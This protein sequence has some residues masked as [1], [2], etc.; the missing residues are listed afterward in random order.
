MT[1]G[2]SDYE[3]NALDSRRMEDAME[4]RALTESRNRL[5]ESSLVASNTKV[6][7]QN[8]GTVTTGDARFEVGTDL[9]EDNISYLSLYEEIIIGD[10]DQLDPAT[11]SIQKPPSIYKRLDQK[12][13]NKCVPEW[14]VQSIPQTFDNFVLTHCTLH[15]CRRIEY[16]IKMYFKI[17][18]GLKQI[19]EQ[20]NFLMFCP[21]IRETTVADLGSSFGGGRI[22]FVMWVNEIFAHKREKK[23]WHFFNSFSR[24]IWN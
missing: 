15:T 3:N 19:N 1:P 4:S 12:T 6:S 24:M 18:H 23:F 11:K 9:R 5:D 8:T 20:S 2:S 16:D 14:I 7:Y 13:Q 17:I 22:W 21:N 10:Y